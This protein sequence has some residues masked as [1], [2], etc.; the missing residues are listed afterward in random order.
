MYSVSMNKIV[1]ELE[2]YVRQPPYRDAHTELSDPEAHLQRF[3]SASM[4]E[5]R[6]RHA[7]AYTKLVLRCTDMD[8][9]D[10]FREGLLRREVSADIGYPRQRDHSGHTLY[11]YL[12]GWYFYSN[13]RLISESIDADT[14]LRGYGAGPLVFRSLWPFASL[15]HDI[16]YLFEGSLEPLA[17][18]IQ[19]QQV[20][21]GAEVAQDY[22][23]HRFWMQCG[24]DSVYERARI[25]ELARLSA[26]DFSNHSLAGVADSLR[27]LGDL[28]AIRSGIEEQLLDRL[29]MHPVLVSLS[30]EGALPGDAFDVWELHYR[31]FGRPSMVERIRWLR[32]AFESLIREGVGLT[33]VRLLDHGICS[34]L[35]LLLYSTFFFRVYFGLGARPPVLPADAALWKKFREKQY[36]SPWW[37]SGVLWGTSAAALHN[38]QQQPGAVG[39]AGHLGPLRIEEDSL[40]YLGILVDCLQEWDRYNVSHESVIGGTLPLQGVD[41]E[42]GRSEHSIVVDYHDQARACLVRESLNVALGGWQDIVVVV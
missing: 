17:T 26:P 27:S 15:L 18:A 39:I 2:S 40:A 41:V 8:D 29:G 30:A 22:F 9:A 33:G 24:I 20:G 36:D 10:H 25:R 23:A 1:L 28:E 13:S 21:A 4:D 38:V 32:I 3:L 34:G 42:L 37:F 5:V 7:A 11:N 16:G 12:L 19:Q 14:A 6:L 35:L 31:V